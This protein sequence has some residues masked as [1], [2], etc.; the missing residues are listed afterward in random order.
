MLVRVSS[1]ELSE[2]MAYDSIDPIGND[3]GELQAGISSMA[4]MSSVG[5]KNNGRSYTPQDFMAY[6]DKKE[7]NQVQKFRAQMQHLVKKKGD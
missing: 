4:V 6:L 1:A 5:A 3:R 2:W 7:P